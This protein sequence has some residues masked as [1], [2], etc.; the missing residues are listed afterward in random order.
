VASEAR[1][2]AVARPLSADTPRP[3]GGRDTAAPL[4]H[5]A[6]LGGTHADAGATLISSL[7]APGFAGD[8]AAWG[9]ALAARAAADGAPA[10]LVAALAGGGGG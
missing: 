8:G 4:Q 3:P 1:R 9:A 10:A 7:A 2:R 6:I 5:R